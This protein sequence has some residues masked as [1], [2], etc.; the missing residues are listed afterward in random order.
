MGTG[1]AVPSRVITN[2]DLSKIV[3][4]SDDW[5]ATRTGIRRRRIV[6]GK[7]T[8]SHSACIRESVMPHETAGI[9]DANSFLI[10]PC[11]D[12]ES[13]TSLSTEACQKAL[14]MAGVQAA[15][16]DLVILCTSTPEDVFGSA[17]QVHSK[18]EL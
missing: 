3:D 5:I 1:S 11:P 9:R 2:D 16:V 6:S 15:D 13:L 4:T 14:A 17:G 12:G 10:L 8:S 7:A 18:D